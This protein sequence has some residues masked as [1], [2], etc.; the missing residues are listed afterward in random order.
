MQKFCVTMPIEGEYLT[1][2][3]LTV[4][5]LCALVGLDVDAIEDYKVCVTESLLLLKR[6][7]HSAAELV[8][9]VQDELTFAVTGTEKTGVVEESIEDEISKALLSALLGQ[10]KFIKDSTGNVVEKIAFE[11]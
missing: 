2:V 6:N 8:F 10:V 9:Y 7:G 1:T 11:G 5:G 3:R 4:G